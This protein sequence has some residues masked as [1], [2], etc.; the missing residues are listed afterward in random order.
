[1]RLYWNRDL[2]LLK[3]RHYTQYAIWAT[4]SIILCL[5]AFKWDAVPFRFDQFLYFRGQIWEPFVMAAPL[6]FLG[7]VINAYKM[8]TSTNPPEVHKNAKK[9]PLTGFVTSLMAGVMEE[10]TFR[11][12]LFFG[13]MGMI[14][15]IDTVL[16]EGMVRNYIIE[17]GYWLNTFATFGATPYAMNPATWTIGIAVLA[18]N[19]KFQEGHMY[20]GL[21]GFIFS[22]IGGMYFFAIMFQHGLYAA[23]LVHFA[24]DMF[25]F[26]MLMIDIW[27][28]K[29]LGNINAS[30]KIYKWY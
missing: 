3:N 12:V 8:V 5:L 24:F 18:S 7:L 15:V 10:L 1:M 13:C 29:Q 6:F 4:V 22:W 28:E 2:R 17:S 23:M 30:N 21:T 16:L 11:W 27:I 25:V 9:L 19:W 20:Q 14:W 26:I